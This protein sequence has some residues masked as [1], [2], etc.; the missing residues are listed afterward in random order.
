VIRALRAA[1]RYAGTASIALLAGGTIG[2]LQNG[3]SLGTVLVGALSAVGVVWY[4][5]GRRAAAPTPVETL[6]RLKALEASTAVPMVDI[7]EAAERRAT[8]PDEPEPEALR[9]LAGQPPRAP[10]PRLPD[11][12]QPTLAGPGPLARARTAK[13]SRYDPGGFIRTPTIASVDPCDIRLDLSAVKGWIYLPPGADWTTTPRNPTPATT[14]YQPDPPRNP[15]V[16]DQWYDPDKQQM[17]RYRSDGAWVAVQDPGTT[18]GQPTLRSLS[19]FHAQC[20]HT[21]AEV[22]EIH[23]YQSAHPV[24][25]RVAG[26]TACTDLYAAYLRRTAR[27]ATHALQAHL[28]TSRTPSAQE[29]EQMRRERTDWQA[30]MAEVKGRLGQIEKE[31]R[32]SL[33]G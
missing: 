10:E 26:C 27:N 18:P 21:E 1:R 24:A 20:E 3:P 13:R 33:G 31:T 28:R 22:V 29:Y 23:S 17:F 32:R 16:G 4:R 14:Y 30:L 7:I 11:P 9:V 6:A 5:T 12:G 19:D 25:R 8:H 2:A 15:A